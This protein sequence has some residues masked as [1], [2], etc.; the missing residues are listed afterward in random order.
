MK[1]LHPSEITQGP[2]HNAIM[3]V[4]KIVVKAKTLLKFK[5]RTVDGF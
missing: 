2:K 5:S 4:K 1:T 3:D